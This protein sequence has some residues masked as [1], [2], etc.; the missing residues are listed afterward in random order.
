MTRISKLTLIATACTL[1][2][3]GPVLALS[4][5]DVSEPQTAIVRVS[6]RETPQSFR[7]AWDMFRSDV[8]DARDEIMSVS[9]SW[10]R[11]DR[12]DEGDYDDEDD[13]DDDYDDGEDDSDDDSDSDDGDDGDD[14]GDDD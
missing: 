4:I 12:D 14:D 8:R 1:T 11:S 6:D 2:L 5:H 13:G 10:D 9:D 3:P 7:D